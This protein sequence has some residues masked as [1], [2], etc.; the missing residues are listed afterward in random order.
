[1][2]VKPRETRRE[3]RRRGYIPL[4]WRVFALNA[5]VLAAA[6]ALT[7]VVLPPHVLARRRR[8]RKS[9]SCSHRSGCML[10]INLFLLRHAFAPLERLT[11]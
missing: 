7:V 5:A 11:R 8:R 3:A 4:L 1:M 9:R 10:A 6:V 2:T